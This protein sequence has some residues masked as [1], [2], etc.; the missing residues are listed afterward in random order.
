MRVTYFIGSKKLSVIRH[1]II[2]CLIK[3]KISLLSKLGY[4]LSMRTSYFI[5]TKGI[6]LDLLR[7]S[8]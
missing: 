7:H 3:K 4:F 6:T 2:L 1:T 8:F 5:L